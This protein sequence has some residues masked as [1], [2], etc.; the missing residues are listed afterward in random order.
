MFK[1][2]GR[3]LRTFWLQLTRFA[4]IYFFPYIYFKKNEC[5]CCFHKL[6][7]PGPQLDLT[8]CGRGSWRLRWAAE[9]RD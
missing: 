6:S 1:D 2:E 3:D 5:A 7:E 4:F 9:L 8:R